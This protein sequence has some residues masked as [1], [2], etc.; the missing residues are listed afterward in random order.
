M[1]KPSSKPSRYTCYEVSNVNASGNAPVVDSVK[2]AAR[3]GEWLQ[4]NIS[5]SSSRILASMNGSQVVNYNDDNKTF[6][7]GLAAIGSG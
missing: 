3:V 2:L 4:L 6:A 5:F 7:E 1:C